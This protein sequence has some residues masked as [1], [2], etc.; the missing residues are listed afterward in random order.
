MAHNSERKLAPNGLVYGIQDSASSVLI[1]D[2]VKLTVDA[3]STRPVPR[4]EC[5]KLAS[6][7]VGLLGARS[8]S[9]LSPRGATLSVGFRS[10]LFHVD[11][12]SDLTWNLA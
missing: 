7:S 5:A 12:E 1:V 11:A 8:F 3:S 2:P 4:R 10:L 9:V 6:L